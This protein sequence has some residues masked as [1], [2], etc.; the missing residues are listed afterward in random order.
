MKYNFKSVNRPIKQE[1]SLG[2]SKVK[3]LDFQRLIFGSLVG[4]EQEKGEPSV[5]F[6]VQK[7]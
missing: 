2:V 6:K 7:H 5:K 1:V 4:P 3:R